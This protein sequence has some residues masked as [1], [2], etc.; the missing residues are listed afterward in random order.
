MDGTNMLVPEAELVRRQARW[1][2][3]HGLGDRARGQRTRDR[4]R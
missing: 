3:E 4:L 1:I 2:R